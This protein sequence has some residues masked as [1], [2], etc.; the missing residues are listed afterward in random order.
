VVQRLMKYIHGV[1]D[2]TL[3]KPTA[4]TLGKFD[5]VH[6]GHQKL[7]AIV[8][9]KA[10]ESELLSAAFT[11]DKLPLSICPQK[12]QHFIT[13][14]SERRKIMEELGLDVE[15]EFPFTQEFMN[16]EPEEFIKKVI[17]DKMHAKVV[18]VGTDFRFG[19]GRTGTP[20]L[21]LEKGPEYGFG[22]IVVEKEKYHDREISSTYVREELK[23]GHMETVN[24]LLDRPYSVMG[25]VSL[26]NQLGRKLL[27]PTV[28]V[29]PCDSKLL[30]P[31]GVYA[32]ITVMD[33]KEY[34][35]VTNL[36]TKPT[37]SSSPSVS[38]ETNLFG[39]NGDAYG[40]NIEVKLLHFLRQEMKF[41]TVEAL[42]KQMESDASFAKDMFML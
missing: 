28:N 19:R 18:V 33:G 23:L 15:V 24:V 35:G 9:E 11:F 13:T 32:S 8:N 40:K 14:N 17:I 7:I 10:K 6:V 42:Q 37:V 27:V 20:E 31:N 41:D 5:G 2:F 22:A 34:Y 16:T 12:N 21:L 36:G 25:I 26:G 38:V 30:P 1:T 3:D 29:Y 39:Y 4:V